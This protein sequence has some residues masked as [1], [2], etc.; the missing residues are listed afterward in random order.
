MTLNSGSYNDASSATPCLFI[1]VIYA[2]SLSLYPFTERY[3]QPYFFS[4]LI[5]QELGLK[6]VGCF[7]CSVAPY[8][9]SPRVPFPQPAVESEV[10]SFDLT[11]SDDGFL[12]RN[13]HVTQ[14]SSTALMGAGDVTKAF[15][16]FKDFSKRFIRISNLSSREAAIYWSSKE[17]EGEEE[18]GR[19]A[20][21]LTLESVTRLREYRTFDLLSIIAKHS[22][23]ILSKKWP[24]AA[25]SKYLDHL[26]SMHYKTY[27]IG[28]IRRNRD[29]DIA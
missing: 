7:W 24:P 2:V 26:G 1:H 14:T 28:V 9:L 8:P 27:P 12:E 16:S 6:E 17:L 4:C 19:G 3:A 13:L 21:V 5:R 29:E 22:R 15:I 20:F 10:V 18:D 23:G 25:E 11:N